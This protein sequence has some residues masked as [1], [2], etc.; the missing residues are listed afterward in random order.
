MGCGKQAGG[1][2]IIKRC[3]LFAFALAIEAPDG[4]PAEDGPPA[5]LCRRERLNRAFSQALAAVRGEPVEAVAGAD[6]EICVHPDSD[7]A[8]HQPSAHP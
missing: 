7:L 3:R 6:P 2:K 8:Y 4:V 1:A 5:V